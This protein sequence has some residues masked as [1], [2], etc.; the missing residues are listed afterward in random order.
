MSCSPA[1]MR[2]TA[3]RRIS[4]LTGTEVHPEARSSPRVTGR[5]VSDMKAKLSKD[6]RIARHGSR[7][8]AVRSPGLAGAAGRGSRRTPR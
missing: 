8:V 3:L 7:P 5:G 1:A 4:S 6:L 2:A